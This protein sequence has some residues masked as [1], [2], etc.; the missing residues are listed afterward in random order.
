[1]LV[2]HSKEWF[3][4]GGVWVYRFARHHYLRMK[5][6]WNFVIFSLNALWIWHLKSRISSND[7]NGFVLFIFIKTKKI[8][9]LIS[10]QQ[11]IYKFIIIRGILVW[12]HNTNQRDFS[13]CCLFLSTTIFSGPFLLLQYSQSLYCN[14]AEL[15]PIT[16]QMCSASWLYTVLNSE[17]YWLPTT[18]RESSSLPDYLSW[19]L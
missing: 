3:S 12:M 4:H 14:Y 5:L 18:A 10:N 15:T 6:N 13:S 7:K 9:I 8:K 11:P 2:K 17:L 1:M 16:V 19:D